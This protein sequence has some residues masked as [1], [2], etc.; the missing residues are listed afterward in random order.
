MGILVGKLFF[1]E[2]I[3][4]PPTLRSS[5]F[6]YVSPLLE[7]NRTGKPSAYKQYDSLK[8]SL[9]TTIESAVANSK[10]ERVSLY[11]QDL[12]QGATIGLN[13]DEQYQPKSLYKVL[14]MMDF[15]FLTELNPSILEESVEY[16][17]TPLFANVNLGDELRLKAG[18]YA[19]KDIIEQMIVQ[20]DNSASDI[21]TLKLLDHNAS[22]QIHSILGFEYD[23][24]VIR[25]SPKEYSRVFKILYNSSYLTERNSNYALDL[26]TRTSFVHGLRATIP[27][28]IPVAH[29]FGVRNREV[30]PFEQLHDCGIVYY[31]DR[32]YLI[33]IMTE[34][35]Q[36][37]DLI[38]IIKDLSSQV[39]EHV[40]ALANGS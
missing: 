5:Q 6:D 39:Y 33:C 12:T 2:E 28:D 10:A 9:T 40:D 22:G 21:L 8:A 38:E 17:G 30:S 35:S 16:S 13:E 31:P 4:T 11:F 34:G 19:Y 29:K 32:P 25:I 26:L 18:T 3:E 24:P 23:A 36:Q 14:T 20:S 1:T 7:C 15:L 37:E 27:E